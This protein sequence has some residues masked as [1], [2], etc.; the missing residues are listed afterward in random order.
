MA[1][2]PT[3]QPPRGAPRALPPTKPAATLI[4]A[5]LAAVLALVDQGL[6]QP[7][8]TLSTNG[9]QHVGE[10]LA[11]ARAVLTQS[12]FVERGPAR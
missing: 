3:N 5:Q 11:Q 6:L 9:H 10:T 4:L 8:V 12:R 2:N 7:S 1:I